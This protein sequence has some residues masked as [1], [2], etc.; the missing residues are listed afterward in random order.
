VYSLENVTSQTL[1]LLAGR[2]PSVQTRQQVG[3]LVYRLDNVTAQTLTLL[4]G[5]YPSVQTRQCY[6]T[7]THPLSR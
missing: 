4:A 5:R 7:N 2:Y 3:I 1:T 6:S